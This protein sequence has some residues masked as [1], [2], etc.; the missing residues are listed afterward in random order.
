[1]KKKKSDR[2]YLES[3]VRSSGSES[4]MAQRAEVLADPD[5]LSLIPQGAGENW[6]LEFFWPLH[7]HLH[8]HTHSCVCVC[9]FSP[10]RNSGRLGAYWSHPSF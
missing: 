6:P 2:I 7:A 8:T 5:G 10:D 3:S 1:M 9:V 4:E